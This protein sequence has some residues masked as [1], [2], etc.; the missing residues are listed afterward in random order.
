MDELIF[1]NHVEKE[2]WEKVYL[3]FL[4][5]ATGDPVI[6][7]DAAVTARRVRMAGLIKSGVKAA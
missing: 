3:V 7:A 4:G 1:K 2:F 6:A 5:Q